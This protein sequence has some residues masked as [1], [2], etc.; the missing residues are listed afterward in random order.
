[1]N[2]ETSLPNE[3]NQL[4]P[5]SKHI[6]TQ[7]AVFWGSDYLSP[8]ITDQNE[9]RAP[10]PEYYLHF[11]SLTF[12]HTIHTIKS[13]TSKTVTKIHFGLILRQST[14]KFLKVPHGQPLS[15]EQRPR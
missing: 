14:P 11:K 12:S 15:L 10:R 13:G 9:S 2:T 6:Q 3:H 4:L 8:I 1:M 5:I 7:I